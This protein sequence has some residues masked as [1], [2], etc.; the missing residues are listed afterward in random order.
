M[1]MISFT[2]RGGVGVSVALASPLV[3]SSGRDPSSSGGPLLASLPLALPAAGRAAV[4][5]S[6][7][8]ELSGNFAVALVSIVDAGLCDGDGR[9]ADAGDDAP[10]VLGRCAGA[11]GECVAS[12]ARACSP[13]GS[14]IGVGAGVG[15]GA[16]A[17]SGDAMAKGS[18]RGTG[19]V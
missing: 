2:G 8:F 1:A 11:R 15:V 7:A 18:L 5:L 14:G 9:A 13:A 12:G 4:A 6:L 3:V 10:E 19:I 17:V 16:G